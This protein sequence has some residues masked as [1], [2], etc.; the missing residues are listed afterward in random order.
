VGKHPRGKAQRPER[1]G[2]VI[3]GPSVKTALQIL[4]ARTGDQNNLGVAKAGIRFQ[5]ATDRDAVSIG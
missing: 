2:D 5:A 1:F 4:A 3:R